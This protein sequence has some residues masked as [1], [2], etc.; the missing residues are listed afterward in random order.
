MSDMLE[1]IAETLHAFAKADLRQH[2][3]IEIRVSP[4]IETRVQ[5]QIMRLA[6]Y[7]GAEERPDPDL[8]A[9]V[10]G[11]RILREKAVNKG[12]PEQGLSLRAG[13]YYRARNGEVWCC[14]K[15]RKGPGVEEHAAADCIRV[16]DGRTEYFF[17]DGRYDR[18]GEREH[19]LIAEAL[20]SIA[21]SSG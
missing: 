6:I 18:N 11:V 3:Q 9:T 16:S 14:Y 12:R 2:V 4:Q 1:A 5:S 13:G 7:P 19:T 21:P 17:L 8:I 15:V 10:M 20:P